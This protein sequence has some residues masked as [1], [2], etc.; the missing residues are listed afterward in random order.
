MTRKSGKYP[1]H[2]IRKQLNAASTLLGLISS[3][4]RDLHHWRSNQRPQIVELKLYYWAISQYRTQL[5]QNWLVM[6]IARLIN[7]NVSCKLHLYSLQRT[8]S[9]PGPRLPKRIGNTHPPN[10][11][12]LKG[13]DIDIIHNII[14]LIKK[15]NVHST[16]FTSNRRPNCFFLKFNTNNSFYLRLNTIFLFQKFNS[17]FLYRKSNSKLFFPEIQ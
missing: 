13:K 10:Y 8:W 16:A 4:Y 15:E 1:T 7:L 5:T 9:P 11:Y 12:D 2:D 17:N 3:V 6:V 14:L